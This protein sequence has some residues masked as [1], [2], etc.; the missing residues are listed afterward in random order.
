MAFSQMKIQVRAYFDGAKWYHEGS[1]PTMEEYMPVTVISSAL[2]LLLVATSFMGL[3]DVATKDTFEWLFS[4]PKIVRASGII[5]RLMDDIV[6][7]K[8]GGSNF[9]KVI[10]RKFMSTNHSPKNLI[11]I[12]ILNFKE[13]THNSPPDSFHAVRAEERSCGFS[14]G[15][16]H[17]ATWSHG[18]GSQARAMEAS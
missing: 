18:G 2:F 7:H 9:D 12:D 16:L 1:I 4:D 6:T 14:C 3:G 17:E 13:K 10:Y 15:V 5:Y 8:V 11:T